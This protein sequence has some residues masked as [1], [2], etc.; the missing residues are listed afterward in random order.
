MGVLSVDAVIV[1]CSKVM[2]PRHVQ[3]NIKP[4][5]LARDHIIGTIPASMMD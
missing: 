1:N 2:N 3:Q 4:V 5:K